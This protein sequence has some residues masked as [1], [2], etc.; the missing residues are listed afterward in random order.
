MPRD[1][2]LQR[3]RR[4]RPTTRA[5]ALACA[6]ATMLGASRRPGSAEARTCSVAVVVWLIAAGLLAG[7]GRLLRHGAQDARRGR[8]HLARIGEDPAGHLGELVH[9]L[10][11]AV[12]ELAELV[13]GG[14]VQAL[15]QVAT[16]DLRRKGAQPLNGIRHHAGQHVGHEAGDQQREQRQQGDLPVR[17]GLRRRGA[18]A[19]CVLARHGELHKRRRDVVGRGVRGAVHQLEGLVRLTGVL[20]CQ[21][22]RASIFIQSP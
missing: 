22:A 16:R 9:H 2:G 12:R 14:R 4:P 8:G 11:E 20:Q 1:D 18:A 6:A 13:P 10:V 15:A 17:A 19:R 7:A 5:A 3:P 21:Q